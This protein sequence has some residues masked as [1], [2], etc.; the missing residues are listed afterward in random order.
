MSVSRS[1]RGVIFRLCT[2]VAVPHT[3]IQSKH[4]DFAA[5]NLLAP[6]VPANDLRVLTELFLQEAAFAL[7]KSKLIIPDLLAVID[8]G[9]SAAGTIATPC[10]RNPPEN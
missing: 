3:L 6:D 5:W 2:D 9:P 10:R 1:Y 4:G 8:V 7:P